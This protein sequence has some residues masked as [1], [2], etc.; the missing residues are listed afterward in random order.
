M[1]H[2]GQIPP[3]GAMLL[4][5]IAIL[6]FVPAKISLLTHQNMHI[7][8]AFITNSHENNANQSN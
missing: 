7:L 3:G 5:K 8:L 6:N 1:G 2:L 4:I